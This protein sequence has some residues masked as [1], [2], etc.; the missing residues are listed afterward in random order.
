MPTVLINPEIM[1]K[2]PGGEVQTLREAGFEVR[3]PQN[4]ELAR[5]KTSI[6]ETIA[7][8]QSVDAVIASSEKYT[9]ETLQSLPRLRV[10]ARAGVGYDAVNVP[11]ATECGVVV[12]ITPTANHEAVAELALALLFAVTKSLVVHDRA[13]RQGEWPRT[14]LQPIRTRTLGVFGL[15][16]IGRSLAVRAGALGMRVIATE[17]YPDQAFLSSNPIEVVPFDQLLAESDFLSL[18]SPLNDQTWGLFDSAVFRKMKRGSILINTSRGQLVNELDLTEALRSGQLGGAGLDVFQQ[19]P[20]PVDNPLLQLPNV[21][22]S[23]HLGG[24]DQLSIE[25]M[26]VEAAS[27][28]VKLFRGD[29]PEGAVVNEQLRGE[30]SWVR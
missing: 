29:W 5:G 13:V 6:E 24:V 8:L 26:G 2:T 25:A 19:E 23:P 21:V 9:P 15:G 30:W 7:E 10:I 16:R 11:A 22:A 12:T 17:T 4:P 1:R 14:S 3:Y 28:I 27:C 20:P 18:H